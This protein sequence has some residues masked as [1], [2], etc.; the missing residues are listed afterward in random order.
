[1]NAYCEK[2]CDDSCCQRWL[3]HNR[4]PIDCCLVYQFCTRCCCLCTAN[5]NRLIVAVSAFFLHYC[6]HPGWCCLPNWQQPLPTPLPMCCNRHPDGC[7]W[8]S[9]SVV[10]T[11]HFPCAHSWWFY[12]R[13][14]HRGKPCWNPIQPTAHALGLT[15]LYLFF[16]TAGRLALQ[17]VN[18]SV[19]QPGLS[20]LAEVI[21]EKRLQ[22][23]K[24]DSA[25]WEWHCHNKCHK[26]L[27]VASNAV[28]TPVDF[29]HFNPWCMLQMPASHLHG[30]PPLQL[31]GGAANVF[32]CQSKW[33]I[34]QR[35]KLNVQQ[36]H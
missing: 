18:R 2:L 33:K 10:S 23:N 4:Y 28:V 14:G 16:A 5:N 22:R 6:C 7:G 17:S 12:W 30:M 26:W 25:Q 15:A 32:C 13:V 24:S 20:F 9:I 3:C 11:V 34:N 36:S 29:F 27:V 31:T 8:G 21:K 19:L 1:M 35:K